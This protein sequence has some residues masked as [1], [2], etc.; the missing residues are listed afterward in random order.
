M[1]L[2]LL[3]L[4]S[5]AFLSCADSL[6]TARKPVPAQGSDVGSIPWNRPAAGEGAGALGGLLEG[7]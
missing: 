2:L 7:R 4:T 6:A 1:K 5:L 3:A